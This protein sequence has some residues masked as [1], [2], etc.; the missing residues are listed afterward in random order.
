MVLLVVLF[1]PAIL[2][3]WIAYAIFKVM[4]FVFRRKL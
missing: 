2:T 1:W 4:N 3:S